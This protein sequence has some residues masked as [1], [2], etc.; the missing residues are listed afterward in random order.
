MWTILWEWLPEVLRAATAVIGFGE[1][2]RR[3]ALN[4]RSQRE[5]TDSRRA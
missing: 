1:A 3:V 5:E 2:V 4:R